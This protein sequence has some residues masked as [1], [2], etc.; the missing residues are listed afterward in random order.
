MYL[1]YSQPSITRLETSLA[2][3][4]KLIRECQ[5]R[6]NNVEDEVKYTEMDKAYSVYSI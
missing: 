4:Q 1:Y 2:D 3:R 6:I 5:E